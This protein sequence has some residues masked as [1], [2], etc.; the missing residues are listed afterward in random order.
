[1][2]V[3]A[4]EAAAA[5]RGGARARP[6][7]S[8]DW[9]REDEGD[10]RRRHGRNDGDGGD[11]WRS[12]RPA[13]S[14]GRRRRRTPSPPAS[15]NA[16]GGGLA[17]LAG[18]T[19]AQ[20]R[21]RER[22]VA[23]YR[24]DL[25]AQIEQRRRERE[26]TEQKAEVE[27]R[28]DERAWHERRRR[29]HGVEP[30]REPT[31][32]PER[33]P[34]RS[35]GRQVNDDDNRP[36]DARRF[37]AVDPEDDDD[38]PWLRA[39]PPQGR[40][41]ANHDEDDGD[42][43]PRLRPSVP[44]G[45]PQEER[46]GP[47]AS[48]ARAANRPVS[49]WHPVD[50]D[51]GRGD[52]DVGSSPGG[53]LF[54]QYGTGL[55]AEPGPRQIEAAE[56]A[57]EELRRDLE[58]QVAERDARRAVER[59]RERLAEEREERE[60]RAWEA[61]QRAAAEAV[62]AERLA[63]DGGQAGRQP[64]PAAE[65]SVSV[66]VGDGLARARALMGAGARPDDED[67]DNDALPAAGPSADGS[68]GGGDAAMPGPDAVHA[69]DDGAEVCAA[70]PSDRASP[71]AAV[72]APGG[73]SEERPLSPSPFAPRPKLKRDDSARASAGVAA[74]GI[75]RRARIAAA[76]E[77]GRFLQQRQQQRPGGRGGRMDPVDNG[78]FP[79]NQRPPGVDVGGGV[80]AAA[81]WGADPGVGQGG[82]P[83]S[84]G[85]ASGWAGGVGAAYRDHSGPGVDDE[86][87]END[88]PW[89]RPPA[90]R[91]D[92]PPPADESAVRASKE[93]V[94]A[95]VR[96]LRE[97]Q[98]AL[99]RRLEA[100]AA[101]AAAGGVPGGFI[102]D[103]PWAGAGGA[104]GPTGFAPPP[105]PPVPY[106]DRDRRVRPDSAASSRPPD[107]PGAP[108]ETML[109]PAYVSRIPGPGE[110]PPPAWVGVSMAVGALARPRPRAPAGG[111]GVR[112]WVGL[113]PRDSP[114]GHPAPGRG[115][116]SPL[117]GGGGAPSRVSAE[118]SASLVGQAEMHPLPGRGSGG[119][120]QSRGRAHH[121]HPDHHGLPDPHYHHYHHHPDHCPAPRYDEP[122]RRGRVPP[123]PGLHAG[124]AAAARAEARAQRRAAKA[125]EA[126]MEKARHRS[127]SP[128]LAFGP[129][130][131]PA[132]VRPRERESA[133][134]RERPPRA[135]AAHAPRR[136]HPAAS[137][138]G[139]HPPDVTATPR[140]WASA[141]PPARPG[142]A[143]RYDRDPRLAPAGA[144]RGG[145]DA[146]DLAADPSA[147]DLEGVGPSA[148]WG[149]AEA[150]EEVDLAPPPPGVPEEDGAGYLG[151]DRWGDSRWDGSGEDRS[152][153]HWK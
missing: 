74:L 115:A 50:Q 117:P 9:Q 127:R 86:D 102:A 49:G 56:R 126:P 97:E 51:V 36:Y 15:P 67:G 150:P 25:E 45:L 5:S 27:R 105:P 18:R 43:R 63:R 143:G 37:E 52:G 123:V 24:A 101:G 29:L 40:H 137:E 8:N 76:E 85:A 124:G 72:A 147:A 91:R 139:Y 130:S 71:P 88:W 23:A 61:R 144:G 62:E 32:E 7:S 59:E 55:R 20:L 73:G 138:V 114:A 90:A 98:S 142:G 11:D 79:P 77:E 19:D 3:A 128:G 39:V 134:H 125:L 132:P 99:G 64:L 118:P 66:E 109:V 70:A 1:M 145:S 34:A 53:T 41:G 96:A 60:A 21:E 140:D 92:G 14:R 129:R 120:R 58:A 108:A 133:G 107:T 113:G 6:G 22:A 47:R 152:A 33:K 69:G 106:S 13:D 65:V 30:P 68:A 111:W 131:G 87:G 146:A 10:D 82:R 119:P 93:S 136:S 81:A 35:G 141:V 12:R 121:P 38:R 104:R 100:M 31:P 28:E 122:P 95:A 135:A 110:A 16:R 94:R 42:E 46:D 2:A 48:P 83:P 78:R 80:G 116:F 153:A 75:V 57:R 84:A 112:G 26:A 151:G 44:R 17:N 103:G 4:A 148:V 149:A 89:L 54:R